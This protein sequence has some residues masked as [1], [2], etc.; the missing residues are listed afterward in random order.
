VPSDTAFGGSLLARFISDQH[1]LA[2]LTCCFLRTDTPA[3]PAGLLKFNGTVLNRVSTL[4]VQ[5]G[6]VICFARASGQITFTTPHD[7]DT[8]A[9]SDD[10]LQ[11]GPLLLADRAVKDDLEQVDLNG[12]NKKFSFGKYARSFFAR[13]ET[14]DFV[15]G[16]TKPTS[17]FAIV[18]FMQ[19]PES[20][21]GMGAVDAINLTGG[22]AAGLL[23]RAEPTFRAGNIE[24][25]L[26]DAIVV[27]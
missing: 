18:K 2:A 26:P 10:C 15:L 8:V 16:V 5:L 27:K 3:T 24:A 11:A 4:E 22:Y 21:G 12:L 13:T 1:S 9:K 19:I 25:L 17:L 20:G 7:R 6:G 23:V 14:G